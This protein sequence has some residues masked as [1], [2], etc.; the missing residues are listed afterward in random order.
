MG[1]VEFK[2]RIWIQKKSTTK[3]QTSN[4]NSKFKRKDHVYEL[5]LNI[6]LILANKHKSKPSARLSY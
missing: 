2:F 6:E 3:V 1:W 4:I 5:S